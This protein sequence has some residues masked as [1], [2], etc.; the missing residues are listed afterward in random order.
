M[1]GLDIKIERI[2]AG[3]KQYEL[4]AS[5]GIPQS[6]LCEIES[7]R[8]SPQPHLLRRIKKTLERARIKELAGHG[9]F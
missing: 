9:P 6:T 5:L 4:A 2:K 7:D 1:R 3:I 8:R